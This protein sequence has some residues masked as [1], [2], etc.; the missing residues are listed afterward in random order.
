MEGRAPFG[1]LLGVFW[2]LLSPGPVQ[3]NGDTP[4]PDLA[5]EQRL[6]EQTV[7]A[8]L[9]GE[10]VWLQAE[11]HRFL[12][13]FT[14][15]AIQPA[16]GGIILLHG[17][18]MH[19][20][21]PNVIHPLRTALAERGWY[22]LSL[23]MPVLGKDATY[24][25]YVA[26]LPA[27]VPRIE[28]GIRFLARRGIRPRVLLAHSCGVHMAMAWVRDHGAH[29]I[30]AFV[31]IGM[32]ATDKGQPLLE[33]LP[34]DRL[35]V[36]VLD[37]YGGNDY[38][39]VRRHAP[40][41]RRAALQADPASRQIEIPGAGHYFVGEADALLDTIVGWLDQIHRETAQPR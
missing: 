33:P 36:P 30:D 31:G 7:D 3:A 21:W 2:C 23:Q 13:I 11:R 28:A 39:A 14:E 26:I 24:Y 32:G 12:A 20:D 4:R 5:R 10:P 1:W 6:A 25:D 35:G 37:V 8:I 38:P 29:G 34:L 16:R 17:R 9:D 15:P 19:P 40:R 18:G 22:T 41:R 27:A